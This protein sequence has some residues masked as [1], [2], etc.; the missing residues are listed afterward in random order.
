MYI[1]LGLGEEA[2][3]AVSEQLGHLLAREY[4]LYL[5][6]LNFHWNITGQSFIGLHDLLEKH[7][8]WLK[9]AVDDIAERI[10]TIGYKA[11][12]SYQEYLREKTFEL[13]EDSGN[14]TANIM[15]VELV[16]AH[17]TIIRDIRTS[18]IHIE[19]LRDYAS[20]DLLIQWLKVHEK[21]AWM[22]RSH[23]LYTPEA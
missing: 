3:K 5:K 4:F 12:G 15:L 9:I 22:L 13:P 11:P 8:E 1:N 18:L 23:L 19:N 20:E 10:R 14:K 21:T 17:E 7:Y 6:T 16:E 2:R